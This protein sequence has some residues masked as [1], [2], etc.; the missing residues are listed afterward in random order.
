MAADV[1]AEIT[2]GDV[3]NEDS[4]RGDLSHVST[5]TTITI[6]LLLVLLLILLLLIVLL[7]VVVGLG[8]I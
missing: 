1:T 5:R 2:E 4:D 6:L 8:V 3:E 7:L